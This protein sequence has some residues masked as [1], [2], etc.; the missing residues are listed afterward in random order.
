MRRSRRD[1]PTLGLERCFDRVKLSKSPVLLSRFSHITTH[2]LTLQFQIPRLKI[3][4]VA[5]A[6]YG[7]NF[8]SKAV[9]CFFSSRNNDDIGPYSRRTRISARYP[10]N[11][12]EHNTSGLC[13]L[14][15]MP[16]L[17]R[18]S[19]SGV[20]KTAANIS[21]STRTQGFFHFVGMVEKAFGDVLY[22]MVPLLFGTVFGSAAIFLVKIGRRYRHKFWPCKDLKL[23]SIGF[24]PTTYG[25]GRDEEGGKHLVV[26]GS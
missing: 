8:I 22:S 17:E 1:R 26:N 18:L 14:V 19:L 24:E 21:I 15:G 11:R 3:K 10:R 20:K 5:W 12:Q 13:P 25:L 16:L 7:S 4:I 2:A 23:P 6:S 9:D